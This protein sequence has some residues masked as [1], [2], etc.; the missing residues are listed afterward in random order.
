MSD[1]LINENILKEDN[2]SYTVNVMPPDGG[3]GSSTDPVGD[4]GSP[5]TGGSG[6][7]GADPELIK[8][9]ESRRNNEEFIQGLPETPKKFD[10]LLGYGL[11]AYM[12]LT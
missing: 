3:G 1:V 5:P 9:Y 4:Y 12:L 10:P 8:D 6:T 2:T 11:L 7:G